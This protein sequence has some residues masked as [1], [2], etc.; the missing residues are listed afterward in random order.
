MSRRRAVG[1][2][3]CG[4]RRAIRACCGPYLDGEALPPTVEALMRSRY[5]AYALGRADYVMATTDPEGPH[6][7][8]DADAWRR[9][10]LEFGRSFDF[11]GV[12]IH[13]A[14]Q[15]GDHGTVHFTAHLRKKREDHSF[16]EDSTFV[17]RD[18]RWL[19]RAAK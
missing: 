3:P 17:R 18:G 2:C 16:D 19:Y 14:E 12:T 7:E 11:D 6:W 1:L 5:T 13:A 10:I 15:D 8:A 4:S 9:S